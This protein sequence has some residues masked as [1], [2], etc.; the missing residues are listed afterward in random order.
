MASARSEWLAAV[1]ALAARRRYV[2]AVRPVA[3]ACDVTLTSVVIR[4]IDADSQ[5]ATQHSRLRS[6]GIL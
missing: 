1:D 4:V 3:H 2:Q 6:L 5:W